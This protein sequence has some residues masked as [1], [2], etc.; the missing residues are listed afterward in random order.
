MITAIWPPATNPTVLILDGPEAILDLAPLLAALAERCGQPG[1]M[2]WLPYFLD[3]AAMR[4]K[5]PLLV[6][7]LRPGALPRRPLAL[8]NLHAAALFSEY[9]LLGRRTGAVSTEDAVGFRTVIAPAGERARVAVL[10]ARALVDRGA[11]VVLATFEAAQEPEAKTLLTGWSGVLWAV[12]KRSVR[13]SLSLHPSFDQ[14]LARMGKSTRFNLRYYR[15]RLAKQ[16]PCEFVPEAAPLLQH[17]GLQA[18]NAG[19]L[20]PVPVSEFARR[21]E[22]ASTLPDSFLMG[23]RIRGGPWLSLVGGWRQDGTTVLHWQMNSSGWQRDSI[24][25]VMRSYLLEHEISLGTKKLLI[26]GGTAHTMR[27]SFDEVSVAD[28]VVRRRS[29]RA[30]LVQALSR[31]FVSEWSVTGRPNFLAETLRN[32][33]LHWSQCPATEAPLTDLLPKSVDM[34]KAR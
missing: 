31:F 2:H 7:L 24:G 27:H 22:S 28:L 15:R 20:N 18:I 8:H 25:T 32:Q 19:S 30:M 9:R 14:T 6:L 10:A 17:R 4:R 12:R 29:L 26:H 13:R 23:L 34:R 1:A 3:P 11:D 5:S 33:D 16:V 21:V